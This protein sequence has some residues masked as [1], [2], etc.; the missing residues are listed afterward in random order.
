MEPSVEPLSATITSPRSPALRKE[1]IAF[2]TQKA[3]ELASFRQGMTTETSNRGSGCG[4]VPA[5]SFAGN[6]ASP[7]SIIG[8]EPQSKT[9]SSLVNE[10]S[11]SAQVQSPSHLGQFV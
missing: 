7:S 2:S 5:S 4:T 1:E 10:A 3:N 9:Y 6:R 11:V 8:I